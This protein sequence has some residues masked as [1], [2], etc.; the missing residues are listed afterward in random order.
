MDFDIDAIDDVQS[1]WYSF[2]DYDREPEPTFHQ[3]IFSYS[4]HERHFS[5]TVSFDSNP[6][7]LDHRIERSFS[8][9][10]GNMVSAH[11]GGASVQ[12]QATFSWGGSG[13]PTVDISVKGEIHDGKGNS[14][15]V[16]GT[17]SSN[18]QGSVSVSGSSGTKDKPSD[19]PPPPKK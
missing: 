15:E 6:S 16:K 7:F 5:K 11:Q 8:S 2:P 9:S 12:G 14:A 1:C 19:S 10:L 17:Q 3:T 18:G 4:N 13:G